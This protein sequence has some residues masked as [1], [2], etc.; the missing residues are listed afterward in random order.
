M[1]FQLRY[2]HFAICNWKTFPFYFLFLKKIL[3]VKMEEKDMQGH[4]TRI[5]AQ[6]LFLLLIFFH[7]VV[8]L[9]FG[10]SHWLKNLEIFLHREYYLGILIPH[11]GNRTCYYTAPE[12]LLKNSLFCWYNLNSLVLLFL[13]MSSINRSYTLREIQKQPSEVFYWKEMFVNFAKFTG[14]HLS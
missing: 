2:E 6:G 10:A 11:L 9:F 3:W 1:N 5:S 14:K 4:P 13:Y 12:H 7:R 8:L